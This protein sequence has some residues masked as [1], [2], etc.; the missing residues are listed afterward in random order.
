MTVHLVIHPLNA[1]YTASTVNIVCCHDI[2]TA[3]PAI[4]NDTIWQ[5]I[6]RAL[7]SLHSKDF[8]DLSI[9]QTIPKFS[10]SQDIVTTFRS[11]PRGWYDIRTAFLAILSFRS[12]VWWQ[13]FASRLRAAPRLRQWDDI[14]AM[15]RYISYHLAMRFWPISKAYYRIGGRIYKYGYLLILPDGMGFI[16]PNTVIAPCNRK[17][18]SGEEAS[19][20]RYGYCP[21]ANQTM[22]RVCRNIGCISS[23]KS[24]LI[25][26]LR[27]IL[28]CILVTPF[29]MFVVQTHNF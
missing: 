1:A 9:L 20:P 22:N 14:E 28:Q 21:S 3:S 17:K 13:Y 16:P 5:N 27:Y 6:A 7:R 23:G 25:Y 19:P 10:H 12:R 29:S 2:I 4:S 18:R 8:P 15:L 26:L 24:I 11:I